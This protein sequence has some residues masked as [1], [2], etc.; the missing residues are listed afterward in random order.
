MVLSNSNCLFYHKTANKISNLV[1][2][3]HTKLSHKINK[4]FS[5]VINLLTIQFNLLQHNKLEYISYIF[6]KKKIGNY[7]FKLS[8]IQNFSLDVTYFNMIQKL[9]S[10][11]LFFS[12]HSLSLYNGL[13]KISLY[14]FM[15]NSTKW[16][17]LTWNHI[18]VL[19]IISN[20]Q[21]SSFFFFLK[22]RQ[23]S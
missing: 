2:T 3:S 8:I 4:E 19:K 5:V 7:G 16:Y 18:F 21:T 9:S 22:N 13:P 6:S 23:F 11:L 17:L 14:Y 15:K 1:I 10:L 12:V 20:S